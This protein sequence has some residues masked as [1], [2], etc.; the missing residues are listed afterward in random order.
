MTAIPNLLKS[1]SLWIHKL[2]RILGSTK[3]PKRIICRIT[4]HPFN[5]QKILKVSTYN[6][7]EN[8]SDKPQFPC[9]IAHYRKS[10]VSVFQKIFNSTDKIFISG[11]GLSTR[12]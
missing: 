7:S 11:G 4:E 3:I 10:S 9:E 1:K 5:F 8:I 6:H 12:Q 2:T